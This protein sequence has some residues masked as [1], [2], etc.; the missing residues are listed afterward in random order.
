MS[1]PYQVAAETLRSLANGSISG[2]FAAIGSALAHPARLVI[3]TNATDTDMFFSLD[4]ANNHFFVAKSTYIVL[5]L[6]TNRRLRDDKF[7][8]PQGTTFYVKQVSAPSSGSV[9]VAVIYGE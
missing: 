7:E 8:L 9:Y 4:G 5:D 6:A 2:S 1:S 3:M